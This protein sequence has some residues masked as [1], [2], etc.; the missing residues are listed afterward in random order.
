[1]NER[2]HYEIFL[3]RGN[4]G[5]EVTVRRRIGD[6]VAIVA[7]QAIDG[8]N[9]VILAIKAEEESYK[10]GYSEDS[11][12]APPT[13]LATGEAKYLSSEVAGGFTGVHFGLY[14][15]ADTGDSHPKALFR[16]FSYSKSER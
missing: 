15:T 12:D 4:K 5:R 7:T 2:H 14:C 13:W 10:F 3:R 6:L 11:G 8:D 1:M 16:W 9:D